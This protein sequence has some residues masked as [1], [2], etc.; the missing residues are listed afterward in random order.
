M[1]GLLQQIPI[2]VWIA[3]GSGALLFVALMFR[4][5]GGSSRTTI[6]LMGFASAVAAIAAMFFRPGGADVVREREKRAK[7]REDEFVLGA[8]IKKLIENR[9]K[10]RE[11]SEEKKKE[12]RKK[13]LEEISR[14]F[15][16]MGL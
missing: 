16:E 1:T 7:L 15:E 9:A 3:L 14:E 2:W 6:L 13:T 11:K 10:E 4:R 5:S 12:I 8:K